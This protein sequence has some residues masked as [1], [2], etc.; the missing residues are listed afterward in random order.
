MYWS[1]LVRPGMNITPT[2]DFPLITLSTTRLFIGYASF[3]FYLLG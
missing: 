2:E 3:I 1:I